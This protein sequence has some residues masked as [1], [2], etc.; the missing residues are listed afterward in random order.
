MN[1][2]EK[3]DAPPPLPPGPAFP[4]GAT[5]HSTN[6]RPYKKEKAARTGRF[7]P[8]TT[9]L[10]SH[11]ENHPCAGVQPDVALFRTD[12]RTY[13]SHTRRRR[14]QCHPGQTDHSLAGRTHGAGYTRAGTAPGI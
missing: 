12:H 10:L 2:W 9:A 11:A 1:F 13:A 3:K 5:C 4:E 8:V 6:T 14:G 7:H